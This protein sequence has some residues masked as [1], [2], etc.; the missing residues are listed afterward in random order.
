MMFENVGLEVPLY[1]GS[2]RYERHNKQQTQQT[3]GNKLEA[4]YGNKLNVLFVKC[5]VIPA[6]N[7]ARH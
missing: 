6:T 4:V 3:V 7:A 1:I 5:K 2:D